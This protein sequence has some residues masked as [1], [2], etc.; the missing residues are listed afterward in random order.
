MVR[1]HKYAPAREECAS[2]SSEQS[3]VFLLRSICNVCGNEIPKENEQCWF[4][5]LEIS[6][7]RLAIVASEGRVMSHTTKAEAK[8]SKTQLA[9]HATLQE[10]SASDQPSWLTTTFYAE[11]MQRQLQNCRAVRSSVISEFHA[12]MRPKLERGECHIHGIGKLWQ[13]S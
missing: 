5:A 1:L 2:Q 8:R 11:K 3:Y 9:N 12:V 6:T 13:V 10:W 7:E 4:C